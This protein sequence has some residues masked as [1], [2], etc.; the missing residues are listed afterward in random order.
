MQT[1]AKITRFITGNSSRSGFADLK[2]LISS[3][4]SV[5]YTI[6]NRLARSRNSQQVLFVIAE[7]FISL[8]Q[9]SY[10]ERN[11]DSM[12]EASRVLMNLP[13]SEANQVGIYYHAIS[14]YRKGHKGEAE[15]QIIKVA[16]NASLA[17]KARAILTLGE[18]QRMERK[19]NEALELHL[20]AVRTAANENE[21][22]LLTGLMA[23]LNISYTFSDIGDHQGALTKLESLW[24]LVRF[25]AKKY[26]FYFYTYHNDLAVELAEVG[27]FDEAQ[28][29]SN[30]ALASPFAPAYPEWFETREEIAQ[31]RDSRWSNLPAAPEPLLAAESNSISNQ[32]SYTAADAEIATEVKPQAEQALATKRRCIVAFHLHI[33]NNSF[34]IP[35]VTIPTRALAVNPGSA[36]S[37]LER[38]VESIRPRGPPCLI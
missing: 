29:A 11:L 1:T 17:Y 28:A 10:I 38:L 5:Q 33:R 20:E 21:Q 30:I 27:R 2:S 8:A 15:A 18:F 35:S 31:K 26:P 6:L 34:Q 7:K 24:P 23:N 25:V 9:Q 37:I 19:F 36:Q 3:K 4:E 14:N 22:N 32:D 12:E 13:L 16:D